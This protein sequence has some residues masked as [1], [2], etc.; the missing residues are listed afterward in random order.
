MPN[1]RWMLVKDVLGSALEAAPGRRAAVLDARCGNDTALRAE[2]ESLLGAYAD[3]SAFLETPAAVPA[4]DPVEPYIGQM[5][6]SYLIER[7]IGHGG[8]GTV[9]L[10]RRADNTFDRRVAI[11][12]VRRG[13]DSAAV[14]GRFRNERQ[15]LAALDHPHIGALFDGGTTPDGLPY[16]VMEYVDGVP[17]DQYADQHH[18]STTE[19][20]ELCLPILDALQHAHDRRV[21]H[22]DL[23]PNNVL[24]TP[25]GEPKLLDFGIA[26]ILDAASDGPSTLTTIGRPM[27]PDYA[28][29][30]Q[31]RGE[32]ITAS[33]DVYAFGVLLYELLTGHRPFGPTTHTPEEMA[34]LVA[35]TDPERPSSA[36]ARTTAVGSTTVTPETVSATRDGSPALLRQRLNGPLDEI[37]L[38]ALRR[39]RDERYPSVAALADD[40][41]SCL[42]GR[43]VAVAWDARRYRARR[44]V[45]GHRGAMAALALAAAVASAT[46]VATRM[47]AP[48]SPPAS[49]QMAPRPSVAV[50]GF[51]NLSGRADD[52]WLSTALGEMLTTELA[53]G[54]QLRVLAP[55]RVARVRSDLGASGELRL[56]AVDQVRAALVTDHAVE[57]AFVVTDG[58]PPRA[59]RIDL[60]VHRSG[61]DPIAVA[62]TGDEGQLFALVAAVG[63]NLRTGLGL[64]ESPP[65][66]VRSA[67]VGYPQTLEATRLY[68]E[69][70]GKLRLLDAV[71][72]R[73]LLAHAAELEP[74]TPLIQSALASSWTA[75]GYDARAAEAAQKAFDAAAG[76]GRE[77]RLNVEGRLYEAQ[78]KWPNAIEVYRTLWGFFS[79]NLD[80]GLRL[81]ASQTAGGQAK[82]SL[83]T[84]EA[85]R[86]LPEPQ[87]LDPRIDLEE[88]LAAAALGDF[89]RESAAITRALE[90]AERTE[91]R[92]LIA[93]ARLFEGRSHYNRGELAAAEQAL[94]KAEAL[95]L[96]AGDRAGAASALN[97]LANVLGDSEN[98][99]RAEEMFKRSLA[100]AEEIGD[101]RAM[102][103]A[104]NNLGIQLKDQR[105]FD[106]ARRAHERALALRREIADRNWI[107][108]SLSNI[109]VVL[110][111][112]DR[113]GEAAEYYRESLAIMRELGDARGEVRALHNLAIVDRE[114]GRLAEARSE[115][116]STLATRQRIG[117]KRG[118]VIG[119]VELGMVLLAQG[120]LEEARKAQNEA[121]SLSREIPMRA[122]ESQAMFQLAQIARATGDLAEARRLHDEALKIRRASNESRTIVESRAELA[123]L[124]FDEGRPAEAERMARE[125]FKELSR[126]SDRTMVIAVHLLIARAR[127]ALG[128]PAGAERALA[129]AR[130]LA[131]AT[132]RID[133]RH[134][135]ALAEARLDAAVGRDDRA[136]ERLNMVCAESARAG[137]AL[138]ERE[139]RAWL[140][141][142][143]RAVR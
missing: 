86:Q 64:R 92:L 12:T 57:G 141:G 6:G 136:R 108:T 33:A 3:A 102:S 17:I 83:K 113:L 103:A 69:G 60:R 61:A 36:I 109:G 94:T 24:V 49:D 16:F 43:K 99:V 112:E 45:S 140:E 134:E 67:R 107:A 42:A 30:E 120:A 40:L 84:I 115:Y 46:V 71:A 98:V 70:V 48:A 62:A 81:A 106:E 50:L 117:D 114:L 138:R 68:A 135:L 23:K 52:E 11:K 20:I 28:S 143:D 91:S 7:A 97:S 123:E 37:L 79:D 78:R 85:M 59:V 142:L 51:R 26:R 39:E 80:Y 96:A 1:D 95:F 100:I 139:C 15:I 116:E 19:R 2:V 38:K 77:E 9:Y 119:R 89:P 73:D 29:P 87:S 122:G 126:D 34:R 76:L 31:L 75:L 21:V 118:G 41:R 14:I 47:T 44:F 32:A 63:R 121:L 35:E 129:V 25:S 53:G 110:F 111:E 5:F 10:A 128:D 88:S 101:R 93:R 104:L 130:P 124:A 18:L 131:A 4:L 22:R 137:F 82:E 132:E 13:M 65:E 127:L 58:P 56:D 133:P 66:V 125:L 55:E 90:R 105:R 27:T 72:A 74:G 54:G 8:M